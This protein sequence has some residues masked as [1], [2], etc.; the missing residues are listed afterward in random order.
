MP[1]ILSRASFRRPPLSGQET[2]SVLSLPT[3]NIYAKKRGIAN[4]LI[5]TT[6]AVMIGQQIDVVAGD[7]NGTAYR[8]N[9]S[10]ID[11]A[12]ADCA[13]P[14]PPRP[15]PLWGHGSI[16]NNWADLCGFIKP[17]GSHRFYESEQAR[18]IF[19]PSESSWPETE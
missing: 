8:D 17:P 18:C 4:K 11:E 14:T 5:L 2:F 6:C 7:F 15:T 3:S 10:T 19:H 13:L 9:L 1:G 12:F 16:P